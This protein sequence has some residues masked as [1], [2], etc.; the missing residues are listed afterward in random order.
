MERYQL[1]LHHL[2][3]TGAIREKLRVRGLDNGEKLNMLHTVVERAIGEAKEKDLH[4]GNFKKVFK[5]IEEDP[6]W[7]TKFYTVE[8]AT[9][10]R[11]LKEHLHIQD[12]EPEKKAA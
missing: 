9:I 7:K 11:T 4:S 5:K 1:P 2:E 10:E 8:R 3:K 12:E 6:D